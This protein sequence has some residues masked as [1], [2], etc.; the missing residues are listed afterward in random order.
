MFLKRNWNYKLNVAQN[1]CVV[2]EKTSGLVWVHHPFI[3]IGVSPIRL[4]GWLG[5]QPESSVYVRN[6]ENKTVP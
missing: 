6:V 4:L 2:L 1:W 5:Y 3:T